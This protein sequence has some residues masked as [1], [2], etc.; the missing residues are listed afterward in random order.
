MKRILA[1]ILLMVF[2][3]SM[4]G[5]SSSKT[6]TTAAK[7]TTINSTISSQTSTA[8]SSLESE[9][10]E[11]VSKE[12]KAN[13]KYVGSQGFPAVLKD[14]GDLY[15]WKYEI[16]KGKIEGGRFDGGDY[17]TIETT[18]PY[19]IV[20][21][22]KKSEP[23]LILSNVKEFTQ[24]YNTFMAITNNGELYSWGLNS[25]GN[26]GCGD[27]NDRTEP[28]KIMDD[29]KTAGYCY[30]IKN[31]GDLYIWGENNPFSDK[32]A[33]PQ[34]ILGNIVSLKRNQEALNNEFSCFALT[35]SGDLYTWG[36]IESNFGVKSPNKNAPN[37]V[38]SGVKDYEPSNG[39][40][41]AICSA[42]KEN[43]DLYI[44]GKFIT[45]ENNG[46]IEIINHGNL[47]DIQKTPIKV[48]SNIRSLSG[49][50]FTSNDSTI[51]IFDVNH[52][53]E[54]K[55]VIVPL[56]KDIAEYH[57]DYYYKTDGSLVVS[58]VVYKNCKVCARVSHNYLL[59][60]N[61]ENNL[62]LASLSLSQQKTQEFPDKTKLTDV[63][64]A[65]AEYVM[66]SDNKLYFW[67]L[68]SDNKLLGPVEIKIP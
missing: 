31:N 63:I 39:H 15:V 57:W 60:I 5:C 67:G 32:K 54:D 21:G 55:T 2:A 27:S 58:G 7:T 28:I 42:L 68:D 19:D 52:N 37:L 24:G 47:S 64:D 38:L 23:Y 16:K 4:C 20:S 34:K 49:Y 30:A 59:L 41:G 50:S 48:M 45:S 35:A 36:N 1:F 40:D 8:D 10:T 9:A 26:I 46:Q 12:L 18:S 43:G 62:M 14:N 6:K 3:I 56:S 65:S 44:W 25:N 61:N 51:Y 66:T 13:F 33:T 22:K 53:S 17:A 29:V 11:K